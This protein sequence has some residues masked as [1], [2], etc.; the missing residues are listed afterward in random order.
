MIPETVGG[1]A[2]TPGHLANKGRRK[3]EAQC[4]NGVQSEC[5]PVGLE[6]GETQH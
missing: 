4:T 1:K 3:H 5:Q 6:H 2:L